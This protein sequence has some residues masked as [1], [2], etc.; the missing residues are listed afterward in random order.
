[1]YNTK[2]NNRLEQLINYGKYVGK[3]SRSLNIV[4]GNIRTTLM[5]S[6]IVYLN[7]NSYIIVSNVRFNIIYI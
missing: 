1:M 6:N 3:Y 4:I 5:G 2:H 7:I